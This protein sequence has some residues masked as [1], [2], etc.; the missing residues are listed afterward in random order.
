MSNALFGWP[1][2]TSRVIFDM[3]YGSYDSEF[4]AARAG[5]FPFSLVARTTDNNATSMKIRGRFAEPEKLGLVTLCHH[6]IEDNYTKFVFK[7]YANDDYTDQ[8][9]E[10]EQKVWPLV[11]D[12]EQVDFDGGNLWDRTYTKRERAGLPFNRP[13]HVPGGH[14]IQSFEYDIVDAAQPDYLQFG[15]LDIADAK[16]WP[17]NYSYGLAVV[18][19]SQSK[20]LANGNGVEYTKKKTS[21]RKMIGQIS[22]IERDAGLQ[23]FY[24]HLR[25]TDITEP[26]IVWKD[27]DD[28]KNMLRECFMARNFKLGEIT[29]VA[30]NF[31]RVPLNFKEFL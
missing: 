1:R 12:F 29:D 21:V 19:E 14:Y 22:L 3:D 15:M 17:R 31:V 28:S 8:V 2:H 26:F 18:P 7:G 5:E 10:I 24:E 4:T 25:Q 20:V 27:K 9:T 11:Y 30:N 6:N 23:V 13:V 16:I